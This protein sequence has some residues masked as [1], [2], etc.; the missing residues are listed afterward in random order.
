MESDFLELLE[1]ASG[2]FVVSFCHFKLDSVCTL[3]RLKLGVGLNAVS[4][5]D[6]YLGL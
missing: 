6:G 1:S 3:W 2:C 5:S 4:D